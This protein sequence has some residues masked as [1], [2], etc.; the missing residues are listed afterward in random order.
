VGIAIEKSFEPERKVIEE[1][2][3]RVEAL[4]IIYSLDNGKVVFKQDI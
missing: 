4:A 3:I 2:G 1:M